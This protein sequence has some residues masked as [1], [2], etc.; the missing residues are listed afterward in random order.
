MTRTPLAQSLYGFIGDGSAS[1]VAYGDLVKRTIGN[2]GAKAGR[3]SVR[4]FE[5]KASLPGQQKGLVREP[6]R[7]RRGIVQDAG[8][9][10]HPG[11][12]RHD[13]EGDACEASGTGYINALDAFTGAGAG[14]SFFDLDGVGKTDD[15]MVGGVPVGS[16]NFGGM[17]TCRSSL[18]GKL[19][20][21]GFWADRS[22]PRSLVPAASP[23]LG[24]RVWRELSPTDGGDADRM[25]FT[26]PPHHWPVLA[27]R[28]DWWWSAIIAILASIALAVATSTSAKARRAAGA[29]RAP[30]AWRRSQMFLLHQQPDVCK[31]GR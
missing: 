26:E 22:A 18:D 7:Q 11:D 10:R 19:V 31:R 6:A 29:R 5:A 8:G 2:T 27:H 9:R 23:E 21:G 16:V 24:P 14:S 25:P 13:P 28:V 15:T 4:T 17:P 20:V 3:L 1:P 12:R 30:P